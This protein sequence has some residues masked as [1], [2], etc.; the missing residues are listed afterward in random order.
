MKPL[1]VLLAGLL[2]SGCSTTESAQP[3]SPK[4][5]HSL[6]LQTDAEWASY[7]RINPPSKQEIAKVQEAR[8]A[9]DAAVKTGNPKR[10]NKAVE[11]Y[12][13]IVNEMMMPRAK[14]SSPPR[15]SK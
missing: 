11:D 1:L 13:G 6:V 2:I 3:T 15:T 14:Q 12:I 4:D 5:L 9:Y 10:I 8:N 7:A